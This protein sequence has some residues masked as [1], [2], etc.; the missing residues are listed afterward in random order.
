MRF[1]TTVI[2]FLVSFAAC[3]AVFTLLGVPGRTVA[4]LF[5]AIVLTWVLRAWVFAK[6]AE[7]RRRAGP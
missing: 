1:L 7:W 2:V 6:V 3:G 5:G 4:S